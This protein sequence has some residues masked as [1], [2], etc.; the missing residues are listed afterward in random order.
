MT[1]ITISLVL[2]QVS[3]ALVARKREVAAI[4]CSKVS[5]ISNCF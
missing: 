2:R 5:N 4:F 1:A 3:L